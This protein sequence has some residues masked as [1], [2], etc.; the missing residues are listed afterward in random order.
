ML[1]GLF[2]LCLNFIKSDSF[3]ILLKI[4]NVFNFHPIARHRGNKYFNNKLFSNY[5]IAM[6]HAHYLTLTLRIR[7]MSNKYD[8]KQGSIGTS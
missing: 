4:V 8:L 7:Y 1:L 2:F 5:I 6:V 3:L